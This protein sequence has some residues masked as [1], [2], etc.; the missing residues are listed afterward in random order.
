MEAAAGH[1]RDSGGQRDKCTHHR[2]QPADK[3]CKVSP[4]REETV[5]PIQLAA[6]H[7]D[8]AAVAL[9]QRTSTISSN[10]VGHERSQIAADRTNRGNPKQFEAALEYQ[11]SGEW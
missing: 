7:Q 6:A 8:P 3:N 5:R 11:V 1:P 4:T 9:Y 2:Q 10:F